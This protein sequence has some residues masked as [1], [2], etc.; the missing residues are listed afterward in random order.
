LQEFLNDTGDDWKDASFVVWNKGFEN[1][2]NKEI[3]KLFPDL[4]DAYLAINER[5]YDLMEVASK[6]MY[7]DL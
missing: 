5:T 7:F 4:E 6:D 3:G 1:A 2:R